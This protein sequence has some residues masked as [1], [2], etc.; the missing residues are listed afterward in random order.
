M[1]DLGQVLGV[2]HGQDAVV[3]LAAI[4]APGHHPS[5]MVFRNNVMSTFNVLEAATLLNVRNLVLASSIS[6]LGLA[7]RHRDFNPLRIPV[8]ETHPLLSQDCYGLSKMVGEELAGGYVRRTPEL[9][10]TSLR[11][12]WVL[13]EENAQVARN[14]RKQGEESNGGAF[15]TWV[16]VRDA[17]SACRLALERNQ[18]GHEACYIAAPEIFP[19]TAIETLLARISPA[20]IRWRIR[21]VSP[22]HAGLAAGPA[23]L[24]PWLRLTNAPWVL[25]AEHVIRATS[26]GGAGRQKAG[27][28]H[29]QARLTL[30]PSMV[31][32]PALWRTG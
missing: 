2:M 22:A 31:T 8:D 7:Y 11:F 13:D 28:P 3:H 6:A 15:W 29:E 5:E 30:L 10:V 17:A 9:A 27:A 1:Q 16:D 19:A 21:G 14:A 12:T 24:G 25:D 18:P 32:N 4:P 20:T 26:L 23:F